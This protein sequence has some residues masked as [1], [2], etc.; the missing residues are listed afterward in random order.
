MVRHSAALPNAEFPGARVHSPVLAVVD[1]ADRERYDR[2]AFGP[3]A[4]VVRTAD[5][6]ESLRLAT[7]AARASGAITAHPLLHRRGGARRRP[8]AGRATARSTSRST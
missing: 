7:A 3:I 6:D 2:E 8:S 1:A 4:F 5:T